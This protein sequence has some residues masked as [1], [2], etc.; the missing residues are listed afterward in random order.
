MPSSTSSDV[1]GDSSSGAEYL[2]L[3]AEVEGDR[4][5]ACRHTAELVGEAGPGSD[6]VMASWKSMLARDLFYLDRFDEAEPLLEEARAVG[7][8][9]V[10]RTLVPAVDALFLARVGE[11]AQAEERARAAVVTAETETD[12]VWLQG[13]SNED[14]AMVLERAGRIEEARQALGRALAVWEQ[15]RCLPFM[16]RVS[17]QLNSLGRAQV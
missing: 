4:E 6:G 2:A 1:S 8:G 3:M 17:Q 7:W 9:P 16:S 11:L 14:L 5:R 12:N 13:W 15:K 10:E